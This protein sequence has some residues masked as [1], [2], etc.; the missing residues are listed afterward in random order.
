MNKSQKRGLTFFPH[1]WTAKTTRILGTLTILLVLL[2]LTPIS[3]PQ[4]TRAAKRAS[5]PIQHI[6]IMVKENR[7]SDNYFATFPGADGAA[8]YTDP[9]GKVHPLTHAPALLNAD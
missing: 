3:Q 5:Y 9:Q 1:L 7:T 8:T 2:C 6:V 4:A